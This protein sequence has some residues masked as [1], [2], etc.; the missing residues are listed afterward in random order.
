MSIDALKDRIVELASKR[1]AS[2]AEDPKLSTILQVCASNVAV[3]LAEG[4][5]CTEESEQLFEKWMSVIDSR[6]P[7]DSTEAE[8]GRIQFVLTVVS[9]ILDANHAELNSLLQG[10]DER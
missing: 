1:H 3:K 10:Q 9:S 5:S 2:M 6:D 4:I 7:T 8:A